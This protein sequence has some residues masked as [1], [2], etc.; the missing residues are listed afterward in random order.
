MG[1]TIDDLRNAILSFDPDTAKTVAQGLLESNLDVQEII[2][3]GVTAPLSEIGEMFSKGELFVPHLVL[4]GEAANAAIE[5]LKVKLPEGGAEFNIGTVILGTVQGD[6]HD[7]GKTLVK[8]LLEIAGFKVIDLGKD[9][10]ARNF[11]ERAVDEG[12]TIIGLSSLMSTTMHE[13]PKVIQELRDRG[14]YGKIKV[15]VGGAPVSRAWA[16][17]IGADGYGLDASEAVQVAKRLVGR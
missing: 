9:I 3:S 6:L 13:M 14:M 1:H 11:A 2:R 4:A 8:L 15:I 12:A 7:I 10:P 16:E 17:E 5:V